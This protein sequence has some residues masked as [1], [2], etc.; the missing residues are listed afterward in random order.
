MQMASSLPIDWRAFKPL[1]R[2]DDLARIYPYTLLSIRKLVQKRS[3]KLPTPCGSRPYIFR[4]E[5]VRR[6]VERLGR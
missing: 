2:C 5:D 4:R 3:N 6:H 1:L